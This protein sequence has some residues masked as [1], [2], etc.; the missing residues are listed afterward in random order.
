MV[1]A[2]TEQ[3]SSGCIKITIQAGPSFFIRP[4]YLR[5]IKA[6]LIVPGA[7]FDGEE[8]QD[9]ID[10]GFSYSAEIKAVDYLARAEQSRF[11][12]SHKL[13]KKGFEKQYIEC[14]LDYLES[15]SYLSDARFSRAWLNVRRISHAEGRIR[16]AAELAA[17]GID[18]ATASVAIDDFFAENS[19]EEQCRYALKKLM[20]HSFSTDQIVQ[21]LMHSGFS[22]KLVKEILYETE[23]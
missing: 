14:A 1:I 16:L 17:R 12:L 6:E 10:A 21:K 15:V 18:R 19:E 9:I 11:G 22:Y 4:F 8:E 13:S 3:V 5:R 2:T 20:Y 7:V 23:E